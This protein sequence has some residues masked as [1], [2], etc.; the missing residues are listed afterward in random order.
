MQT[1]PGTAV[2]QRVLAAFPPV[3]F[4]A[5]APC[6]N[7]SVYVKL[8]PRSDHCVVA[9]LRRVGQG[10]TLPQLSFGDHVAFGKPATRMPP[11]VPAG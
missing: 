5:C 10:K 2:S 3:R 1:S 4:L 9:S 7:L 6:F 8:L 11:H